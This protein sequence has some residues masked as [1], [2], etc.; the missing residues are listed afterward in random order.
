M[1]YTPVTLLICEARIVGSVERI[2]LQES[3]VAMRCPA[4]PSHVREDQMTKDNLDVPPGVDTP[5][6]RV[7]GDDVFQELD[8]FEH[9]WLAVGLL[10]AVGLLAM[11]ALAVLGTWVSLGVLLLGTALAVFV[12]PTVWLPAP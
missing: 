1:V 3:K 11:A 12:D 8:G 10:V 5:Q 7:A 9:A 4:S 2:P 6:S